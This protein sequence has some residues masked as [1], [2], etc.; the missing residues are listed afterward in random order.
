MRAAPLVAA[1]VAV[2]LLTACH[3]SACV[4]SGCHAGVIDTAKAQAAV[5]ALLATDTGAQVRSVACPSR[6]A[7]RPGATFTCT[8]TGADGTTAPVLI[9]QT[10]GKGKVDISAPDLLHTGT[11]ARAIAAGLTHRLKFAVSAR[12]PDLVEAH[13]GTRLTCTATDPRGATRPVAVTVTDS[14][15]AISYRLG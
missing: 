11:A 8:A 12:C 14:H 1:P 6:V 9:T 5:R 7:L 13:K 3:V 4:G 2:L 10:D 15:G